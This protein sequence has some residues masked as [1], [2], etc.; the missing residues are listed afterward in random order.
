MKLLVIGC[1]GQIGWELV[2]CLQPLGEVIAVNHCQLDLSDPNKIKAMLKSISPTI[3]VNAA[4]YT[5]V[6]KAEENEEKANAI[7]GYAPGVLA[8]EAKSSGVLLIHYSTDYIFDGNKSCPYTEDD[9]PTPINAYGRSKLMGEEAIQS[10]GGDYIIL[11]TSWV[12]SA[13][14]AN[15]LRTILKLSQEQDELRVVSDQ[16]GVP[17]WARLIA[18]STAH[19]ICQSQLQRLENSFVSNSYNLTA[20]GKVSWYD[21]AKVAVDLAKQSPNFSVRVKN[22]V[23]IMSDEYPLLAV[24]PKNSCLAT[25]KLE[26]HFGLKAPK[27]DDV[28]PLCVNEMTERVSFF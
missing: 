17:T 5:A 6:D 13:R 22:I 16:F 8:A 18:E 11:R 4:A 25:N 26:T 14:R 9:S 7:N 19:V 2:R 23:P 15:F 20:S 28:L 1:N 27:W 3:I 10:V 21:F 24:R 12:Y